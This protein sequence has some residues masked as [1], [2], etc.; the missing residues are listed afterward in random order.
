MEVRIWVLEVRIWV[1]KTRMWVLEAR[2]LSFWGQ[3]HRTQ[4]KI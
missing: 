2:I 1:S 4:A 3:D